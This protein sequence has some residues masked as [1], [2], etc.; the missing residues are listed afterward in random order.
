MSRRPTAAIDLT[1]GAAGIEARGPGSRTARSDRAVTSD[2]PAAELQAALA[3]VLA[4]LLAG[5]PGDAGAPPRGGWSTHVLLDDPLC[6]L[7]VV[8]GDFAS[9]P[10]RVVRALMQASAE[11]IF[12]EAAA[13]QALRWQVQADG[14]HA[15][16][17]AVPE[18]L[19]RAVHEALQL[20]QATLVRMEP[21]FARA[22][23][24]AATTVE[25]RDGVVAWLRGGQGIFV[26]MRRGSMAALGRETAEGSA[27]ALNQSAQRLLARHGEAVD[28]RTRRIVL[29]EAPLDDRRVAPWQVHRVAPLHEGAGA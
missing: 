28:E 26:H 12:G 17:L 7:D 23:N 22:W 19:V 4:E 10:E 15:L 14:R 3:D 20:H 27:G 9:Q 2:M 11:E 29:S 25:L 5:S 8:Q 24:A 21:A 6:W 1:L 18:A 16:L 13:A